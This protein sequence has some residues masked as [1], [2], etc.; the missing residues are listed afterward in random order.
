MNRIAIAAAILVALGGPAAAQRAGGTLTIALNADIR[1]IEPGINRDANTDTAM[2]ILYEGLVAHRADLSVGPSLAESWAIADEG[3]TYLFT[4]RDGVTFHN[5]K[6]LTSAEVKWSWDREFAQAGWNCKR[7][8]DGLGGLKVLAVEAP[9][10]RTVIYRLQAPQA[11]FL[12]QLANVQCHV[13]VAHPDSVDAEGKWKT[14]IGTGPYRLKEWKRGEF[15]AFERFAGYKAGTT[16]LS[17]YA[18]ARTAHVDQVLFRVIPDSSTAEAALLTGAIDILPAVEPDRT[19][20]LKQRGMVIQSAPG[21]SWGPLLIQTQ[22]PLLSNVKIRRAIA[23]A[24]D[25]EQIAEVRTGGLARANASAVSESSAL[26]DKR[27][28]DW[29]AYDVKRA[30]ALLK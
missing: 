14:P 28:L 7:S 1:S 9:D 12:K 16:P 3:K 24:L 6:P 8:F 2:H 5:G 21:L 29:P 4:L 22:D 26:F 25:R 10:P 15:V 17:G 27:F 11:L 13:L 19:A 30:Q 20:G 18:G 23:H